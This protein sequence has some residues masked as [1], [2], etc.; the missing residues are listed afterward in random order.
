MSLERGVVLSRNELEERIAIRRTLS[1]FNAVAVKCFVV[2]TTNLWIA[3]NEFGIH[4]VLIC[5]GIF[6]M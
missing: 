3:Y 4:W 5:L 6:V 1:F 2:Y